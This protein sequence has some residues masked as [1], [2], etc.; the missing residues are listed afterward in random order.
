MKSA[1]ELQK[2]VGYVS[3]QNFNYLILRALNLI[4]NG[5]ERG[6]I[7]E[8]RKAV[9]IGSGAVRN[10]IDYKLDSDAET[11]VKKLALGYKL[12]KS[13]SLRNETAILT[14]IEKYSRY[15]GYICE[16]QY[17][18]EGYLYD[19]RCEN[20]LIEFDEP[21]HKYNRQQKR[22][23]KKMEIAEKNGFVLYRVNLLDDIIDMIIYIEQNVHH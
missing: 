1:R 4:R 19:L 22:D 16:F 18:L 5:L 11:L 15:Q 10:V 13:H 9:N 2:K 20:I 8:T 12:G 21:H 6:F 3:W 7:E 17:E 14:L 23:R